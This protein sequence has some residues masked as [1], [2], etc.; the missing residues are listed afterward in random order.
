MEPIMPKRGPRNFLNLGDPQ[1]LPA[2][3]PRDAVKRDFGLR[4]QRAVFAKGWNQSDLARAVSAEM[5]KTVPRDNV[6][7]W[8]RGVALPVGPT[9]LA[10][11]KVLGMPPEELVSP[12]GRPSTE[13]RVPKLDVRFLDGGT[14]WLKVNR[15]VSRELARKIVNMLEDEPESEQ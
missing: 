3:A 10:I 14:A 13:S 2:G 6:S 15:Q 5:N 12:S 1:D 11:A 9:L 8:V 4:L 7:N